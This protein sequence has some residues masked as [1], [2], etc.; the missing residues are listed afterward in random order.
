MYF[1]GHGIE[2]DGVN[3]LILRDSSLDPEDAIGLQSFSLDHL[4]DATA[5]VKNLSLIILDACRSNPYMKQKIRS[6]GASRSLHSV[7]TP[8]NIVVLFSSKSGDFAYDGPWEG[9]S[10]NSPFTR[11]LLKRIDKVGAVLL[12]LYSEV[13]KEVIDETGGKQRP[14]YEGS[15]ISSVILIPA[16]EA[17]RQDVSLS[18]EGLKVPTKELDLESNEE[19]RERTKQGDKFLDSIKESRDIKLWSEWLDTYYDHYLYSIGINEHLNLIQQCNSSEILEEILNKYPE[20]PN[21]E[22]IEQK[23]IFLSSHSEHSKTH[24]GIALELTETRS[25]SLTSPTSIPSVFG[26]SKAN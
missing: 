19:Y 24:T 7:S 21:K 13:T 25:E 2:H 18:L 1:S 23:I 10:S 15:F 16:S 4:F 17:N 12:D 8:P 20:S 14:Y 26:S 5:R 22:Q 3:R 6:L 11:A 9:K